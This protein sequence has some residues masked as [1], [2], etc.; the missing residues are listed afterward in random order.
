MQEHRSLHHA[1]RYKTCFNCN[2]Q[3]RPNDPSAMGG[4]QASESM[5]IPAGAIVFD[6]SGEKLGKVAG[7][8]ALQECFRLERGVLFHHD[9]YISK[10][11]IA[12]IDA[13]GVHLNVTH[14]EIKTSGWDHPPS[15]SE[16]LDHHEEPQGQTEI[17]IQTTR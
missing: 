1:V 9:Y 11:A 10:S 14:D 4:Y 16:N 5:S 2:D 6:V 13:A 17:R 12:R 7:G 8:I 3:I 15:D